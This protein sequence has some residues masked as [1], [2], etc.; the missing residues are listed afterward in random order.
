MD[1]S[2]NKILE[3]NTLEQLIAPISIV[4]GSSILNEKIFGLVKKFLG[5]N[6]IN[7]D[8][9]AYRKKI[10]NEIE[11]QKKY[12]NYI[13]SEN[14]QLSIYGLGITCSTGGIL[15]WSQEKFCEKEIEGKK[16]NYTD[17]ILFIPTE[18][19]NEII[20]ETII[21]I[22]HLIDS[23]LIKIQST[24]LIIFTGGFSYN[25]IFREKMK[26]FLEEISAVAFMKEPQESVMKGAALFGLKPIQIISRIIP[27]T[28]GIESYEKKCS[29]DKI[30]EGEYIDERNETRCQKFIIYSIKRQSIEANKI[31]SHN[32]YPDSKNQK[33]IIYYSYE[34]EIT[35]ENKKELGSIDISD[36]DLDN[37]ILKVSMKFTNYV[38]II[39]TDEIE[40]K[41]KSVL[42]SYPV[43]K[44]I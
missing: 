39:I 19:I 22:K 12:L 31:I 32:I 38:N 2:A 35:N 42:L 25:K 14:I 18:Y 9:L 41:E 11:E 43:S 40:N 20:L 13:N 26:E 10:L 1:F 34:D 21:E 37:K 7:I 23:I 8:N 5:E 36:F 6:K 30:C 15:S 16:L 29:E 27:V 3:N 28:I 17:K 44:F 33:I 24:D 4:K